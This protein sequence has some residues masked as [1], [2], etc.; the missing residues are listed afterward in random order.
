[1]TGTAASQKEH[2]G[3]RPSSIEALAD[4]SSAA[5]TPEAGVR[6]SRLQ[7]GKVV[8]VTGI[9]V[10]VLI[11]LNQQNS[12]QFI[13]RIGSAVCIETG[14]TDLI[15]SVA[16]LSAP[17]YGIETEGGDVMIAELELVG[18]FYRTTRNEVRFKRGINTYPALGDAATLLTPDDQK[19]LYGISQA[20]L[21]Q[22]G[23]VS[24][25]NRI[26]AMVDARNLLTGNF[27]ILGMAGSG[28]SCAAVLLARLLIKSRHSANIVV[29]DAHNEY[30]HSFGKMAKILKVSD[31]LIAHW[32]LTFRELCF[33]FDQHSG[34]LSDEEKEILNEAICAAKKRYMQANPSMAKK[35]AISENVRIT[36][37]MPVPYRMT[38]V[39]AYIDR[40]T[41]TD[42]RHEARVFRSL[43]VRTDDITKDRLY[44][45]FFGSLS[46][47]DTLADFISK[48]FRFPD[49]GKPVT[50]LQLGGLAPEI[51]EVAVSAVI[52]FAQMLAETG[53]LIAPMLFL[54][55]EAHKYIPAEAAA[56]QVAHRSLARVL[57]RSSKLHIS[58]GMISSR[59]QEIDPQLLE[60]CDTLFAMRLPSRSDQEMLF[61][62]TPESST[63]ILTNV[64][65]LNIAEATAIGRG[66]PL[67]TRFQFLRL[68]REALPMDPAERTKTQL[69]NDMPESSLGEAYVNSVVDAW[70]F[71]S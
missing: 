21:I 34:A 58:V 50:V 13:P 66:V 55:E 71:Q 2:S 61:Q 17:T 41:N 51:G 67:P 6:Q 46:V 36:A 19:S 25:A 23:E 3:P 62:V 65:A 49:H 20:G 31:G 52:R 42:K 32:M 9:K 10:L 53:G 54:L 48:V 47:N 33:L 64:G 26:P 29:F 37:D 15:T 18:E 14:N 12:R 30:A 28:K 8:S 38:D 7:I 1:M 63:G 44:R 16:G 24:G 43:R 45:P 57:D 22:A 11:D 5:A 56:Q 35:L 27:G 4:D 59:I 70:R 40:S 69:S 60:R 68:P 39:D